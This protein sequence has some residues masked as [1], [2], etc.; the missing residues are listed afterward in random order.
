M[1]ARWIALS[2]AAALLVLP[3]FASAQDKKIPMMISTGIKGGVM[4]QGATETEDLSIQQQADY[5][6]LFQQGGQDVTTPQS[7]DTGIYGQFGAGPA[8][9]GFVEFRVLELVGTELGLYW[10]QDNTTGWEDKSIE[11]V[12]QGRVYHDLKVG[13][14]H[15]PLLAKVAGKK[16]P[17]KPFFGFGAEFVFQTKA[18]IDYRADPDSN[19]GHTENFVDGATYNTDDGRVTIPGFDDRI[20]AEPQNYVVLQTTFGIEIDLGEVR[21]PVEIR[22]GWNPSY[23]K[24]DFDERMETERRDDDQFFN[25]IYQAAPLGHVG[26]FTGVAYDF[27]WTI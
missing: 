11:G 24:K 26:I 22:A 12:D 23:G 20:E 13:A 10:S 3:S 25:F 16:G 27:G 7:E 4:M 19:S 14:L 2:V 17:I 15:V 9:G 8:I 18:E 6:L 1:N 21:I 5:N